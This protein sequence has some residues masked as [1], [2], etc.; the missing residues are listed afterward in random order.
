MH[1]STRPSRPRRT[2]AALGILILLAATLAAPGLLV[3]P[4][5]AATLAAGMPAQNFDSGLPDGWTVLP[6]DG[7]GWTFNDP[8]AR[9]NKTGGA[10]TFAVADSD[11][12]GQV[13]M[14]TELRS[15][16]VDFTGVSTVRL[17]FQTYF[18]AYAQSTGDVD[19][20]TDGGTTWE[21]VW[22]TTAN[23]SSKVQIDLSS[24]LANKANA[25]I[26]F[27]YYNATWAWYWQIDNVTVESPSAPVAPSD[28]AAT[29]S[30][31][32]IGLTWKDNSGDETGFK[33][34]R[35]PDGSDP[36]TTLTTVGANT[37]RVT[38][39]GC[40]PET[41]TWTTTTVGAN[42]TQHSDPQLTCATTYHYRVSAV[43]GAGAT[44]AAASAQATTAACVAVSSL[45]EAFDAAATPTDWSVLPAGGPGWT[46]NDPGARTNLTGGATTFAI[47]DSDK[48][49]PVAM[50][51]ELR[52]PIMNFA[53]AR[54]VQLSLKTHFR[55]YA[56]STGDIDVSSDGG[57]T[58]AN[59]WRKQADF[60]GPVNLD[61]SAQAA[62]KPA[63]IVRFRYYGANFAWYWQ[64]DDVAISALPAPAK[65][66]GLAATLDQLSNVLLSWQAATVGQYRIERAPAGTS[67]WASVAT[68]PGTTATYID[69]AVASSTGYSYRLFAI[70]ASGDSAASDPATVTTGSRNQRVIDLTV[71]YYDTRANTAAKRVAIEENINYLA[72]AIY[73]MSNGAHQIGRVTIYTDAQMADRA[74]IVWIKDCWPNA[75]TNG[76]GVPGMRI[77][78]CDTFQNNNYLLNESGY[79]AGGYTVA[80]EMGHYFYGVFDEYQGSTACTSA[81]WIGSPCLTDTP[82]QNSAMNSQWNAV[83]AYGGNLNWLN[84]STALNNTPANNTA[85]RREYGASVWE[86]LARPPTQDPDSARVVNGRPRL[87]YPELAAAAPT[88]GQAPAIQLPAG[89]AA[90][91]SKLNIVWDGGVPGLARLAAFGD[92]DTI[93]QLVVDRSTALSASQL[94][95]L[96]AALRG[97]VDRAA[98]GDGVG[99]ITYA[100]TVTT[101]LA[102]THIAGDSD[103]TAINAAIDALTISAS[104]ARDPGAALQTALTALKAQPA[105]VNREVYLFAAGTSTS[106][107]AP[108]TL[109]PSYQ[110]DYIPVFGFGLVDTAAAELRS[111]AET[112]LGRYQDT[113][114]LAQIRQ[115]IDAAIQQSKA[116]TVVSLVEEPLTTDTD[117]ITFTV[118]A[119]LGQIEVMASFS[120]APTAATLKAVA[121]D[122]TE[123]AVPCEDADVGTDRDAEA[124]C[125]VVIAAPAAGTWQVTASASGTPVD[126][127]VWVDGTAK[128]GAV[129]FD[130]VVTSLAGDTVTYPAPLVLEA[131]VYK[132]FPITG[133]VITATLDT[134][135]GAS[136]PLIFRDDGQNPDA[137][138]GDGRYTASVNTTG[139]GEY[140]VTVKANNTA[141]SAQYTETSVAPAI[142]PN[143]E[144][145]QAKLTPVGEAFQRVA[146]TVVTV[147]GSQADDHADDEAGAT[148]LT[149]GG[150]GVA[151]RID[152]AAD[153]DMFKVTVPTNYT[154][155]VGLTLSQL[156][157][158]MDP[159]VYAYAADGSWEQ[160][161]FFDYVATSDDIL[162]MSLP[163]KPGET[164]YVAV[165]HSNETATEGSYQ[166]RLG[167]P[168]AMSVSAAKVQYRV[169]LPLIQ[170]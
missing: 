152:M 51:S 79:I 80:H 23:I 102:I 106:G 118:D 24:K 77:Q 38:C 62:G 81:T 47:A 147:E 149:V 141:N 85:Q 101:S 20:S 32:Q 49:G 127:T 129:T 166:V 136:L 165:M 103:K 107:A 88:A 5:V 13:L 71:S 33:V 18:L 66:V 133:L 59:V 78:H 148:A 170:R 93:I 2:A 40:L 109:A 48:A 132:D 153:Q 130:S 36:W 114:T 28:L 70:N 69:S 123:T 29:A 143:G 161:G 120:G 72:N 41:R 16:V 67:T 168:S 167:A 140:W 119:A 89:Q 39:V 11:N 45:S 155:Q 54:G 139:D 60:T 113:A 76:Y 92:G 64:I 68:L 15:P 6:A 151:G 94:A 144:V 131:S 95:V 145:R 99:M 7:P 83:P 108:I 110:A 27:R 8:G 82:V 154:G 35:S 73:E 91:R 137:H 126:L 56:T 122:G 3:R 124:W 63:V 117:P 57:T 138:A 96:Q 44:P 43:N 164:F 52:T 159:Y 53:D 105:D 46:F 115:A 31:N 169:F 104:D 158:G 9:T 87:Y 150:P 74:N 128:L 142:G 98:V 157:L 111:L 112:T 160:E 121:P 37:T 97:L 25:Q 17:V 65:P 116:A 10:T 12:A 162:A 34:E 30:G 55:A 135:D 1:P 156:G 42:T 134:P 125:H 26:R 61:I 19:V 86:T 50:D 75:H 146:W 100:D 21:N 22:R 163:A 58:W 14:D 90:A 84:F 4:A